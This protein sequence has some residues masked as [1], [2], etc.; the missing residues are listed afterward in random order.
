M[1]WT[2]KELTCGMWNVSVC[3]EDAWG[4]R[5]QRKY[6]STKHDESLMPNTEMNWSS[7]WN[8]WS[9]DRNQNI[10]MPWFCLDFEFNLAPWGEL[11][12]RARSWIDHRRHRGRRL[13]LSCWRRKVC[14]EGGSRKTRSDFCWLGLFYFWFCVSLPLQTPLSGQDSDQQSHIHNIYVDIRVENQMWENK[15]T[16]PKIWRTAWIS[17]S[18]DDLGGRSA[19]IRSGHGNSDRKWMQQYGVLL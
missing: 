7:W 18:L 16:L 6:D 3:I 12:H 14:Q 4:M 1:T 9:Q 8:K 10:I 17:T 5:S 11:W 15:F 2:N 13:F 19:T